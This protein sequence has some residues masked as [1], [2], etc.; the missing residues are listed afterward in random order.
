[1]AESFVLIEDDY[2]EA[3]K[4]YMS[5]TKMEEATYGIDTIVCDDV[6]FE[7]RNGWCLMTVLPGDEVAEETLLLLSDGKK[8]LYFFSD[9][10]Q[11]D[12]EF[13]A[14]DNKQ[15]IRRKYIY[16]DLPGLNR[17]DGYLKVEEKRAFLQWHDIDY[18]V[19]IAREN[20]NKLF[21]Y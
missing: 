5:I 4:R 7:D 1:M 16:F 6:R 14:I 10:D 13:L 8:M 18:F 11:L 15:V 19:E 17:D 21:E 9:D 3:C 2:K 12:C 20:P